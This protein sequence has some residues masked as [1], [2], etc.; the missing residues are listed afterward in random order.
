VGSEARTRD[1]RPGG[2]GPAG[3]ADPCRFEAVGEHDCEGPH[4]MVGSVCI[5]FRVPRRR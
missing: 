3:M 5:S 1:K 2:A 4:G